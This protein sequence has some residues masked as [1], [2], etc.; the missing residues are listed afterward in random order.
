MRIIKPMYRWLNK[1]DLKEFK[2]EQEKFNKV[3][4]T[5]VDLLVDVVVNGNHNPRRK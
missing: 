2:T 4:E 1:S 5:K 3:I